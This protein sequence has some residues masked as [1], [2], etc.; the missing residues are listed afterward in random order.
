MV[1]YPTPWDQCGSSVEQE[2]LCPGGKRGGADDAEDDL[3]SLI[4]GHQ[5]QDVEQ[6]GGRSDVVHHRARMLAH[7]HLAPHGAQV[8]RELRVRVLRMCQLGS[9]R[10]DL[11]GVRS[12]L[13]PRVRRQ[14][15]PE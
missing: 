5:W 8:G 6:A 1:W 13:N 4:C 2:V 12:A 14:W 11:G 9:Q 10:V 7:R 15:K 3:D